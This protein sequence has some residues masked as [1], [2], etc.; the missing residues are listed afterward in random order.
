MIR[1]KF[2]SDWGKANIV[3]LAT[4][5]GKGPIKLSGCGDLQR[6]KQLGDEMLDAAISLSTTRDA[7]S[8]LIEGYK[9][10]ATE[11]VSQRNAAIEKGED[12]L[13]HQLTECLRELNWLLQQTDGLRQKLLGTSQLVI[14]ATVD[15]LRSTLMSRKVSSFMALS[16][17]LSLEDLGKEARE[18]N[19]QIHELTKKSAQDAAAVKVLTIMMLVYLP[20]TV[21]SVS[22]C[23]VFIFTPLMNAKNFFSTSFVDTDTSSGSSRKLIVLP[24]WW[25]FV[26]ISVPLTIMTLYVWWIFTSL[27][28]TGTYPRWLERIAKLSP[29]LFPMRSLPTDEEN[30]VEPVN[31]TNTIDVDSEKRTLAS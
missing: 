22:T 29:R 11:N 9:Q 13:H 3:L 8:R 12:D 26:V 23:H 16:N 30:N 19:S 1:G 28:A 24:N 18:E 17:G 21:V 10:Y 20:A 4:P 2:M 31:T 6:L 15:S 25:I 5:T 14:N 27:Q 7:V